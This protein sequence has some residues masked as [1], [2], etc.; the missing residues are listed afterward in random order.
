M[1]RTSDVFA[2]GRGRVV[3]VP[4]AH[5]PSHWAAMEARL[6]SSVSRA[7]LPVPAVL[8]V[9]TIGG[10]DAIVF[11]RVSGPSMWELMRRD[12]T[13]ARTLGAL[14]VEVHHRVHSVP[15]PPEIPRLGALLESKISNAPELWDDERPEA[16]FMARSLPEESSLLHGDLHPCN[17]V[18][19]EDGPV[20]IDW[21]DAAMGPPEADLVRTSLLLRPPPAGSIGYRPHL[22]G[23]SRSIL[24][25]VHDSFLDA[26]GLSW[27]G[28]GLGGSGARWEAV[29]AV[30]RLAERVQGNDEE[31]MAVWQRRRVA[32]L[33]RRLPRV[34]RPRGLTGLS[35]ERPRPA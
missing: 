18:M 27:N 34:D 29:L 7:G 15:A 24:A 3:K 25:A 22:P 5:V 17:V 13:A 26:A 1:G 2:F 28:Q 35:I 14:L 8:D 9:V 33:D 23:A 11:E 19:G 30:A 16:L 32:D 10:R 21:F 12:I 20:V 4:R 6:A 31:L